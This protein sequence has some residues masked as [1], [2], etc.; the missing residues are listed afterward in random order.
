M[1]VY[2]VRFGKTKN[3]TRVGKEYSCW[4]L[5]L[6]PVLGVARANEIDHWFRVTPQ[7]AIVYKLFLEWLFWDFYIQFWCVDPN[8]PL[9][10]PTTTFDESGYE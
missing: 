1:T 10:K 5:T 8:Y 6:L 7:R 4:L 3:A 2:K 9:N